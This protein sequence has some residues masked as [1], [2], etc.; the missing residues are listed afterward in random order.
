MVNGN[1]KYYNF[2]L[3]DYDRLND[4]YLDPYEF[5][6]IGFNRYKVSRRWYSNIKKQLYF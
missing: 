4:K 1:V 5:L 6:G 3:D 2:G